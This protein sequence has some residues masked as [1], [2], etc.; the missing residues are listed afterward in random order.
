MLCREPQTCVAMHKRGGGASPEDI[1]FISLAFSPFLWSLILVFAE[2]WIH[3]ASTVTS[4]KDSSSFLSFFFKYPSR[5]VLKIWDGLKV[6][7]QKAVVHMLSSGIALMLIAFLFIVFH[8]ILSMLSF[9]GRVV[10][11]FIFRFFSVCLSVV[12]LCIRVM[13]VSFTQ[14]MKNN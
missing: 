2:I 11:I 9:P 1:F 6:T 5:S 14:E 8:S 7:G 4:G 3:D 10:F 12:C 13:V